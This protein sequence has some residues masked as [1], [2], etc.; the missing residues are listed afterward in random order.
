MNG[1]DF[2]PLLE[3]VSSN[4]DHKCTNS[5]N[6]TVIVGVSSLAML[7]YNLQ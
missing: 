5:H 2:W 4:E 6:L 1:H 7:E 3:V